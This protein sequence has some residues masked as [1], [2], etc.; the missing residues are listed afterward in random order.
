MLDMTLPASYLANIPRKY[1][2]LSKVSD[3]SSQHYHRPEDPNFALNQA[4]VN[5]YSQAGRGRMADAAHSGNDADSASTYS[6][7]RPEDAEFQRLIKETTNERVGEYL[8]FKYSGNFFEVFDYYW[9]AVKNG[10]LG[11]RPITS[12]RIAV[13]TLAVLRPLHSHGESWDFAYRRLRLSP[14]D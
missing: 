13:R 6:D 2:V 14:A 9:S 11:K 5:H 12:L 4:L 8:T 7:Y 3:S 10:G 1:S